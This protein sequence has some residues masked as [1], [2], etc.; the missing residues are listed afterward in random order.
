MKKLIAPL[1]L[2][3]ALALTGC[4]GTDTVPA[5]T[6]PAASA[7]AK[8]VEEAPKAPD[9]TGDW[10][11]SNSLSETDFMTATIA[12]GIISVDWEL[13]SEDITAVY[14]VGTF[15]APPATTETH[16]WS[17]QRDVAATDAALLASTDATKDFTYKDGLISF[18]V[19]I[20]GDSATVELKNQP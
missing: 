19:S 12:D 13:G 15:E 17:S 5:S 11:Q 1:V 14:W 2:V 4:G 9:L 6:A 7:A 8:P 10:K 3:A 18:A 20:Q 16:T